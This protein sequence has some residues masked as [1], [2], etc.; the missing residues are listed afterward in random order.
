MFLLCFYHLYVQLLFYS[1]MAHWSDYLS[2]VLCFI[3]QEE[4]T[5]DDQWRS[6]NNFY[7]YNIQISSTYTQH[8]YPIYYRLDLLFTLSTYYCR[9]THSYRISANDNKSDSLCI[10]IYKHNDTTTKCH[11]IN[12]WL[13]TSDVFKYPACLMS[14]VF[15]DLYLTV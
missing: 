4:M 15:L 7:I 13:A 14:S 5:T 3:L 11:S 2:S 6:W 12:V 10:N 1:E 8:S 9:G